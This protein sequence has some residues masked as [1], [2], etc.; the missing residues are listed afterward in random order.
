VLFERIED[1]GLAH[2]SYVVAC[3]AAGVAAV[4]D[5]RRDV[6]VYLEFAGARKLDITHVLE[7]HIHADFASGA[8]ELAQRAGAELCVS[9]Y[10]RDEL[11]QVQFEHRPLRDGESVRIGRVRLQAL[12][13]PGHTPEH[14]SFLVYDGAR[15]SEVPELLLSGDFLFVGSVGR[16]DLIGEDAKRMLAGQLYESV[17]RLDSLP[18]GLEVHPAHGAGSMCGAGMSARPMS[19]LGF[20]RV[21]NPYLRQELSRDAF[22]QRV[23]AHLPPFPPYYKRMKVVNSR[24]APPL[25]QRPGVQPIAPSTFARLV[26]EGHVVIDLRDPLVFAAAH[27]PGALSIGAGSSV[28]TWASWVVPYETPILLVAPHGDVPESVRALARVGL[29]DVRG[30]LEGGMEA[31]LSEGH[32]VSRIPLLPV[33]ELHDRLSRDSSMRVVDVRSDEEWSEGHI[34]DALHLMAGFVPER[35]AQLGADDAPL[36]VICSTGYRSSV[37]A[38]VLVRA[39]ATRVVNVAGGMNA[40]RQSGLPVCTGGSSTGPSHA[41]L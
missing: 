10:D 25:G 11:Y 33:E 8:L 29:D 32:E 6:D 9:A 37:A 16:P 13:T 19:T 35:A 26:Q 17:R 39:G 38:S 30:W 31:W 14:L 15:T 28:S 21:A 27:V 34:C 3:E 20:E 18:D 1:K 5:P 4:V 7:T 2:Y 40:W 24:G 12:H 41:P 23:L 36:A 22:V